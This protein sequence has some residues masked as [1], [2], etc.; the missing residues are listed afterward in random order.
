MLITLGVT[1]VLVILCVILHYE[2]MWVMQ[3]AGEWLHRNYAWH[4][5]HLSIIVCGLLFAHVLEVILFG[6][7]YCGLVDGNY[8]AIVGSQSPGLAECTYFSFSNYTSLGYGDLVPSG[9]LRFMAGMEALT[10]LVLI[11][12]TASFMYLQMLRVW[13]RK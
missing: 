13:E 3:R 11:A 7:A 4:R 10:G 8:G 5:L 9:P 12:W 2:S 6:L 1:L